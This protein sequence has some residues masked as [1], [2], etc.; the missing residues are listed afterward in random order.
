MGVI[1]SYQKEPERKEA[2]NC[3]VVYVANQELGFD[4]LR[5]NLAMVPN[6]VVQQR[7]FR[8][9]FNLFFQATTA[10]AHVHL[11]FILEA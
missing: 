1:Q 9:F 7:P 3:D 4:F 8:L 2:Y 5:D 6:N 11:I 10:C